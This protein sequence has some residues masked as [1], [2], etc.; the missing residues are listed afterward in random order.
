MRLFRSTRIWALAI[1]LILAATAQGSATTYNV[2][3]FG[4]LPDGVTYGPTGHAS[5]NY[6]SATT[7]AGGFNTAFSF[8][9]QPG[10]TINF[11]VL[12]LS[13]FIFSDGRQGP[14]APAALFRGLLGI[15]FQFTDLMQ[16]GFSFIDECRSGD[17]SCFPYLQAL[18]NSTPAQ[19][20]DLTFTL[21]DG[22]IEL[23]W[24]NPSAYTRRH[25]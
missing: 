23:G 20:Y 8:E 6:C 11:G 18:L 24:T 3:M 7:C 16:L 13:P 9:A 1:G 2:N 15:S 22:F 21:P 10:D 4:A 5:T 12:A 25:P 14:N 17:P 19:E